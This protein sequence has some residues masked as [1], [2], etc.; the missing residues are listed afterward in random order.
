VV[1]G[2]GTIPTTGLYD[3]VYNWDM[4]IKLG[5]VDLIFKPGGDRTR[6]IGSDGWIQVARGAGRNL[7]SDP[8]LSPTKPA[9]PLI[10]DEKSLQVSKNQSGNFAD[11][12]KSRKAPVSNIKDAVRSDVISLLCDIAVRTG[13]KI[14]WDPTKQELVDPSA[15]AKA[16]FSRP[17]R[18]PWTL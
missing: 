10:P 3:T 13:E 12:I 2:T 4:K 16:M 14:I 6:F 18:G 11:A 7:A 8:A 9:E 17:M 5:E 15:E 1:E